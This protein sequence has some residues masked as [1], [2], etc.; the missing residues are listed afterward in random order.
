V[1]SAIKVAIVRTD[2]RR[3]AVAEA[4]GLIADDLRPRLPAD[5]CAVIIPNLDNPSRPWS[6][7]H[8]DTLSATVDALLGAGAAE[9]SVAAGASPRGSRAEDP[10]A[11]LGYEAEVWGRPV[12]FVSPDVED[13][14]EGENWTTIRLISPLGDDLS[15]RVPSVVTAARFRISLGVAKTHDVYRLSLGLTNLGG[16]LDRDSRTP[17]AAGLAGVGRLRLGTSRAATVLE[18]C[19][20]WLERAWLGIRT[21][22]G[23]MRLTGRELKRLEA[24]ESATRCLVALAASARPSVSLID[25]FSAMAGQGPR[26][27]H[28]VPLNTVIA[29]TDPVA[30]DAVAAVLMGFPPMEIPYLRQAHALGLGTADLSAI[31]IVGDSLSD[32]RRRVRRHSSDPLLRLAARVPAPPSAPPT[33]H[34]AKIPS[35]HPGR[36]KV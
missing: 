9:I 11:R 18:T 24:V 12:R 14:S 3:G 33:P 2:R 23:G 8:P 26:H 16:V 32:A 7:T 34:F 17:L 19:R 5:H 31:T 1:E 6:C 13:H 25:A 20:G 27:G 21:V 30:V 15:F 36:A 10:F 35:R 22:A 28:R 29:G 4:L